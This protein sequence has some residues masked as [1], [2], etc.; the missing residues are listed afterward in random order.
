MHKLDYIS[1]GNSI[2]FSSLSILCYSAP[3]PQYHFMMILLKN[4]LQFTTTRKYSSM[5]LLDLHNIKKIKIIQI[6]K[7]INWIYLCK[8]ISV[9]I[10][11]KIL[12]ILVR[13]QTIIA[14]KYRKI[15][16][17]LLLIISLT[18]HNDLCL[19]LDTRSQNN[20]TQPTMPDF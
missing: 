18:Q 4:F 17:F 6:K 12:L 1:R 5:M 16:L 2:W 19:Y 10:V 8:Q 9:Q 14:I 20:K 11:M 13:S 15:L 7:T 3:M